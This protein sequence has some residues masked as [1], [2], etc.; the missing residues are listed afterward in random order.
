MYEKLGTS[1]GV[2][3]NDYVGIGWE[4]FLSWGDSALLSKVV[5]LPDPVASQ[6]TSW[7]LRA[8]ALDSTWKVMGRVA[9][10]V[11]SSGRRPEEQLDRGR[12]TEG[13]RIIVVNTVCL[14][15]RLF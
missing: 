2:L 13:F 9:V 3:T 12:G 1:P 15:F 8:V 11:W 10:G 7:Q 6:G 5:L 4:W 14:Y